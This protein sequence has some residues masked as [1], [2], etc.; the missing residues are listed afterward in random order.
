MDGMLFYMAAGFFYF[1]CRM[2]LGDGSFSGTDT[3]GPFRVGYCQLKTDH[4]NACPVFYP[5]DKEN[6]EKTGKGMFPLWARNTSKWIDETVLNAAFFGSAMPYPFFLPFVDIK[7]P[8]CIESDLAPCFVSSKEGEAPARKLVPLIFCHGMM[9]NG[10][11]YSMLS[12][13]LASY[14]M[15]VMCPDFMDGSCDYTEN[16]K[17]GEPVYF[18]RS[19]DKA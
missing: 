10:H 11:V 19:I 8:A 16:Q 4:G 6:G 15:M 5:I 14:G 9:V 1:Y 17:T 13:E 7:I 3:T 2:K 12:R 18:N